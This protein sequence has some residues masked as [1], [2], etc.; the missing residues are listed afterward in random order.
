MPS[1]PV[2]R[3]SKVLPF[4]ATTATVA[5]ATGWPPWM[6]C[7]NTSWL[8]SSAFFTSMP[9]SVTTIRRLSVGASPMLPA[10][11]STLSQAGMPADAG[12]FVDVPAAGASS[13]FAAV[14][15]RAASRSTRFSTAGS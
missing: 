11:S 5:P 12:A 9:R 14:Q 13:C 3:D 10:L 6:D 7:T 8:P 2:V 4:T 15:R 1:A